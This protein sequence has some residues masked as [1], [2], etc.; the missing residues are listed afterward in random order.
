MAVY[1]LRSGRTVVAHTVHAGAEQTERGGFR[2]HTHI[3]VLD[4]NAFEAFEYNPV[5][6]RDALERKIGREPMLDPSTRLDAVELDAGTGA[7]RRTGSRDLADRFL[8]AAAALLGGQRDVLMIDDGGEAILEWS[9]LTLPLPTR[10]GIAASSGLVH[11]PSRRMQ[12]TVMDAVPDDPRRFPKAL[13]ARALNPDTPIGK[14]PFEPWLG[15][16]ARWWHE[17][18]FRELG[19]LTSRVQAGDAES[20]TRIAKLCDAVDEVERVGEESL[21]KIVNK[22]GPVMP[23]SDLEHELQERLVHRAMQRLAEIEAARAAED[24]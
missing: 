1:P 14:T 19:R 22:G 21:Q 6:V 10:R 4:A 15:L 17:S 18:R 2:V 20:L 9:L 13:A 7:L 8:P 23:K 3:A 11:S 5:R 12:L 16:V 24:R